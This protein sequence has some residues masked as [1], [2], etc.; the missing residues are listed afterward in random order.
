M[1]ILRLGTGIRKMINTGYVLLHSYALKIGLHRI[2]KVWQ[3]FAFHTSCLYEDIICK[4]SYINP[5]AIILWSRVL[6]GLADNF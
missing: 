5:G 4:S 3:N 2:L 6:W 1:K